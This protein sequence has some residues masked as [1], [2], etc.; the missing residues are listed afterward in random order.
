[1]ADLHSRLWTGASS[2]WPQNYIDVLQIH[3]IDRD[4]PSEEVMRALHELVV[5]GE[6]RCLGASSMHAWEL[7]RL[8]YT[9]QMHD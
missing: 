4:T 6:V 9:T 5:S 2:V 1:M 8:L 3:R 7:A